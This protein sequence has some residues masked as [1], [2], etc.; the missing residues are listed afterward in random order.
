VLAITADEPGR[1]LELT[2]LGARDNMAWRFYMTALWCVFGLGPLALA[3]HAA[4]DP[5]MPLLAIP[6]ALFGVMCTAMM[7]FAT[8]SDPTL[9][10]MR[11]DKGQGVL[12]L[13]LPLFV[14]LR[15][16]V[17]VPLDELRRV[18]L[19]TGAEREEREPRMQLIL[20]LAWSGSGSPVALPFE[21]VALDRRAEALDLLLR[22]A[23]IAG[24]PGYLVKSAT[25][26]EAVIDLVQR[27][28]ARPVPAIGQRADYTEEADA[29]A[30]E[31]A[32]KAFPEVQPGTVNDPLYH[33][34]VWR[35]GSLVDVQYGVRGADPVALFVVTAVAFGG[36]GALMGFMLLGFIGTGPAS[37]IVR[38]LR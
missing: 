23:R 12:E 38:L 8:W 30:P 9:L 37:G 13:D 17:V 16:T 14:W 25:P 26:R 7:A 5:V 35:P 19:Q 27:G 20:N 28:K 33:V 24:W 15:R 6:V 29:R 11:W 31:V 4:R 2:R 36:L 32:T 1:R 18:T 10:R 21:V 22:M 3:V 34:A